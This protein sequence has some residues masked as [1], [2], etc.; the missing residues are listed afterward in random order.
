MSTEEGQNELEKRAL[1]L[2]RHSKDG[3]LQ[4]DLWKS[5]KISSREGSRLVLR[6]MRKGL[7]RREEV[8]VGGRR[9]YRLYSIEVGATKFSVLVGVGS[10]M[11]IPCATCPHLLECG[12]GGFY[13]PSSC[14]LLEIW[15]KRE[16]LRLQ[17]AQK[18]AR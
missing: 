17:Q 15:L 13:D 6:L 14:G 16:A 5:L 7:V 3:M 4:S 12:A 9:T 10:I 11:D 2:L 18:M 1:E 8:T